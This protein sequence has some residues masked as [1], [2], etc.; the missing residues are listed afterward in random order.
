MEA[1]IV[2]RQSFGKAAMIFLSL[3]DVLV[4]ESLATTE[5]DLDCLTSVVHCALPGSGF[6]SSRGILVEMIVAV[7]AREIT[8]LIVWVGS[9]VGCCW[10]ASCNCYGY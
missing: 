1:Q 8:V 10:C 4:D 9:I 6:P 3:S 7:V 2:G 5:Y